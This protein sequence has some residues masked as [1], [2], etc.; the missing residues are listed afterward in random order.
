MA[1]MPLTPLT[2]NGSTAGGSSAGD[3]A[4]LPGLVGS[5][6]STPLPITDGA[7]TPPISPRPPPFP[8]DTLGSIP[9]LAQPARGLCLCVELLGTYLKARLGAL[10]H[11]SVLDPGTEPQ[12]L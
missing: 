2:Y 1:Q 3:F 9:A 5:V 7:A 12:S 6:T 4:E 11:T 8:Q 10:C